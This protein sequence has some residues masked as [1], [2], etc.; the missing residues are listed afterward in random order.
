MLAVAHASPA[1]ASAQAPPACEDGRITEIVISNQSVFDLTDPGVVGGRFEWAYRIANSLHVRTAPEVIE[2]ELLFDVGDC[3]DIEVLR[4]SERLLRR[5]PFIAD[6]EVFGVRL[7]GDS[8][9]VVVDTQDEWSTRIEPE[10]ETDNSVRLTGISLVEDNVLGTGQQASLFYER[11]DG[12]QIYGVSYD[13]PQLFRTR[14]DLGLEVAKT[15]VGN[16][17][18]QAVVYPFVGETGRF[19]FR[20][21]IERRDRYFELFRP[22]GEG[23]LDRIWQPIRREE[24]EIGVA[25]R[26]GG[27]RYRQTVLGVGLAGERYRFPGS[28]IYADSIGQPV[29]PSTLFRNPWSTFSSV[30]AVGMVGR[31]DVSFAR[32]RGFDTIDGTEDIR[33]GYEAELSAGPTLPFVQSAH[34]VSLSAGLYW[35]AEPSAGLIVGVQSLVEAQRNLSGRPALPEWSDVLGELDAWGYLRPSPNSRH[36]FAASVS[37]VGGWE[38]TIPFQLTLGGDTGLRGYARHLDPGGRRLVASVEHRAFV[39]GPFADLFDMG[40]VLFA[41]AGKIWPGDAP[42]GVESPIRATAGFGIRAAFPPGSRQTFRAD[43]GIPL[44][45]DQGID[46]FVISIGVGQ[47]IGRRVAGRDPQLERSA[48]YRLSAAHFAPY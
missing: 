13:S 2:R 48:H 7:G 19:G 45:A 14:A 47:L 5:F 39:E 37:A 11:D 42:F 21:R 6:A 3:Y 17:Y 38:S 8:V 31:R 15:D 28:A 36:T 18:L 41:D 12:E 16:N 44:I 46:R 40:T 26:R 43:F 29:V 9:Q 20:E 4:D 33:I 10:V 24:A 1:P 22:R 34:D 27:A 32:R 25:F 35:A 23:E 30:R